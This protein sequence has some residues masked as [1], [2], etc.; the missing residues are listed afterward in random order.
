MI[1]K[2]LGKR[3]TIF[4]SHPFGEFLNFKTYFVCVLLPHIDTI[5]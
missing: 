5:V 3:V 2:P 4:E 1:N